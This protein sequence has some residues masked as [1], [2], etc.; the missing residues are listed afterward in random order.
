[1]PL[2]VLHAPG[3]HLLTLISTSLMIILQ[4]FW[5]Y[6]LVHNIVL[7]SYLIFFCHVG[8]TYGVHFNL[9]LPPAVLLEQLTLVVARP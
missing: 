1:M 5:R 6:L 3:A 7:H 4:I 2:M 9:I 8:V